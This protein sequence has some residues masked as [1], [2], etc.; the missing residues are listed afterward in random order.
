[1][2][3]GSAAR[4]IRRNLIMTNERSRT[5][6][7]IRST[8]TK[9]LVRR[10][11]GKEGKVMRSGVLC[12]NAAGGHGRFLPSRGP[13]LPPLIPRATNKK[14][15]KH[16]IPEKDSRLRQERF[17]TENARVGGL[18]QDRSDRRFFFGLYKPRSRQYEK[19]ECS[20]GKVDGDG[21]R[22]R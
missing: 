18:A 21:R 11:T 19:E 10:T 9:N 22:S 1:M 16:G 5:R 15:D 13:S 3:D 17:P 7:A 4:R 2:N 12:G 8:S 6:K 20:V 14:H